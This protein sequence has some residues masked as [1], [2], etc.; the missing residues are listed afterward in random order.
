MDL[1]YTNSAREDI[2]V[3][4]DYELDLA[5]GADENNFEC[6]IA[7]ASHC[8]E[9]GSLLYME[10]TEYG[11]IVDSIQSDTEAQEITYIGRTW[12]GILNSKHR[13]Q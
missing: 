8:C 9:A 13:S 1:I 7:S 5:F 4:L 2:G 12:H 3:L 10:G 6:R 11:G